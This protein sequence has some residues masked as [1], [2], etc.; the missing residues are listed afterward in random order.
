MSNKKKIFITAILFPFIVTRFL[1]IF[2]GL[3][4]P[5]FIPINPETQETAESSGL[6]YSEFRTVDMWARWDSGW[7]VY[8]IKN[9]YSFGGSYDIESNLPFFPAYPILIKGFLSVLPVPITDQF[10]V[11]T[12]IVFSNVFL[13]GSLYFVYQ[14]AEKLFKSEKV[15]KLSIWYFLVFPTSFFFSSFYT[16][17]LFLFLS[18]V[19]YWAATQKKWWLAC[20]VGAVLTATRV[21]G[22]L[23][24][25][26]L[27]LEYLRVKKYDLRKFDL[28]V[29]WFL[30]VPSGILLYFYYMQVLT[31]DFFAALKVQNAWGRRVAGPIASLLFPTSFKQYVTPTDQFFMISG[32]VLS[33]QMLFE[34]LKRVPH[35][36]LYS[37]LLI[38]PTLFT[39]TLDSSTRYLL[40]AFPLFLYWVYVSHKA[41]WATIVLL[42]VLMIAQMAYFGMFTQFYWVG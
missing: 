36:G 30:I 40:V 11:F 31:G 4:A 28:N 3:I 10:I 35:L 23:I 18:L 34:K 27:F 41:K 17:S 20:L 22:V 39:G 2:V 5:Q 12:G 8:I 33:V 37:L 24:L 15:A 21:V 38:I 29:L 19:S 14:L 9:G 32:L 7:Y 42:V 25:V 1:L 13:V 26:P 16:E 6:K